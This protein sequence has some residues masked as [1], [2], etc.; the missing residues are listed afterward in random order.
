VRA[1]RS[2]VE[3]LD[4]SA[5]RTT[6]PPVE[7]VPPVQ[8][9]E[10]SETAYSGWVHVSSPFELEITNG[11]QPV[12]LDERNQ[13][14]LAPGTHELRFE[15]DA[16]GYSDVRQVEI[17]PGEISRVAIAPAPSTLTVIATLPAEV[18]V[19]GARAGATP[20]ADHPVS[21]GTHDISVRSTA[22]ERRFTVTVTT[23]P[24]R[25]DVDFSA[26]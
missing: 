9:A 22:G 14:L 23:S 17:T 24:T 11:G 16:L 25:L 2:I 26:P 5:T 20:L 15:N 13:V 21:L 4:W 7:R 10:P 6:E 19:D 12:H 1:G 18:L 8:I 3:K